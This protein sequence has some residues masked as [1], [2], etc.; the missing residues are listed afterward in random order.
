MMFLII[1]SITSLSFISSFK[2]FNHRIAPSSLRSTV[3]DEK[4]VDFSQFT[5][6]QEFEGK[7]VSA[8]PFGVFVDVSIGTNVLLPRS[9]L[10][11]GSYEKLKSMA[12]NKVD[13]AIKLQLTTV[14]AE[15]RTLSGKYI[16]ANYKDRADISNL[17][18]KDLNSKTFKATV[19]SAHDFG[20]FA[21][22]VDYGVEGLVPASKLPT[23][24]GSIQESYLAGTEIDVQILEM[25]VAN[26]KLVF[27]IKSATGDVAMMAG[28]AQDKWVSG[29]VESVSNFGLF[30]RPA[31]YDTTGLVHRS[32][33]PRELIAAMK[34]VSPI[35][36]GA[37]V[38]DVEALFRAGD[39]IK[40]RVKSVS[41]DSRKIEL[42]MLPYSA[43]DD[44][45]DDYVVD[46]RDPEGEE[47]KSFEMDN[48][49]DD[50]SGYDAQDTL[51][52]WKG[53]PYTKVIVQD[54]P[55]DEETDIVNESTYL[56][57]GTWRRLFELDLRADQLDFSSKILEKEYEELKEEIG[58]LEGLDDELEKDNLLFGSTSNFGSYVS[59]ST[60][61]ADWKE[62]MEYCREKESSTEAQQTIL[63]GGK[64]AE[65][66]EFEALLR[67]VELELQGSSR[68]GMTMQVA[69]P[70]EIAP[71]AVSAVSAE[72]VA[73]PVE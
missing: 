46:G 45:E 6:G 67:E 19:I 2:Y 66:S 38:T 33:V 20:I 17:D 14:S 40:C 48:D 37:N 35:A 30:V 41:A 39:V 11:K 59:M 61:P 29:I 16:P 15:N 73:A 21:E 72:E 58:E 56:V 28:V 25:N 3:S 44:E 13:E 55:V 10:S 65:Q 32:Q 47:F 57:E 60:L 69:A 63:R 70:V 26:K 68:G 8:L 49:D 43:A 52:W 18:G 24:S 1:L 54:G 51:L 27:G 62:Q 9:M 64:V 7:L 42:S 34:Q 50:K 36:S 5:V 71:V 31:G 22:L 23:M 53:Q 12:E 4:V